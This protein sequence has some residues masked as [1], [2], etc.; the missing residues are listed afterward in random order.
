MADNAVDLLVAQLRGG[1]GALLRIG[2]VVFGDEL[3]R[4]RVACDGRLPVHHHLDAQRG[5]LDPAQ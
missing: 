2:C 1:G 3:E 5:F 4:L